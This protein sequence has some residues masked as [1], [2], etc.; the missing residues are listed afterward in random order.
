MKTIMLS[1]VAMAAAEEGSPIGK[2]IQ[3]IAD[4]Q[5]KVQA[6]GATAQTEY[7]EFAGWC[8][9]NA[10][11]LQNE[12][13]VGTATVE[14]L[15]ATLEEEAA[16]TAALNT[17]IEELAASIET[18]EADLKAA[19]AVRAKEAADFAAEEKELVDVIDVIN[20]AVGILEKEMAKSGASMLQTKDVNTVT[21]V[22]TT[23]V[24]A[25]ALSTA[26]ASKLTAFVQSRSSDDDDSA[27]A[28]AAATYEN[29]SGGIVDTLAGLGKEAEG[30]LDEA[31]KKEGVALHQFNMLKASL[32]DS[33][34]FATKESDAAKQGIAA[35][36]GT[37]EQAKGDLNVSSKDLATDTA[38][39]ADLHSNCLTRAEDHESAVK[40]RGEELAALAKA[41]EII[42][43]ATGGAASFLQVSADKTTRA[44]RLVR[45][46]AQQ[47]NSPMLAQLASRMA[48]T[49]RLN[50]GDVFGKVK[51]LINDMIDKLEEEAEADATEKAYCDKMLGEENAKREE[52]EGAIGKLSTQIDQQSAKAA[53]LKEQVA[54]LTKELGELAT[55]QAKMDQMR[56]DE[57]ATFDHAEAETA[58][59][60]EGIKLAL[61]TLRDYYAKADKSHGSSDG[62]AGGIVS[63]LEVCESDFSKELAELRSNEQ[64]AVAAYESETK[65]NKMAK[66]EKS[67]D[68]KYKEKEAVSLA[69]AAS[70]A[71]SDRTGLQAEL[72]AVLETLKNLDDR[73]S[74][75]AESYGDR[76]A[77][78][79]A[80]I[81]GLKEALEILSSEAFVQSGRKSLRGVAR[82]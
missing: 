61:K 66:T 22:L 26:D 13:K 49:A 20:R 11:N 78:R 42:I 67:Q 23:L 40:S 75:K 36:A 44:E 33:V 76:T 38:S 58:K 64:S 77:A 53:K 14:E 4:L 79:A 12:I 7:E 10:K 71:T 72:D 69:K 62:A 68:V 56:G 81:A 73:C 82:H 45:D 21:Q 65:E 2:V 8:E 19:T 34:K 32:T 63:L 60:L 52:L 59:G 39:L 51:G 3:M 48:S 47:H 5:G 24:Q 16:K 74:E 25:T 6:E 57:K 27:S 28:P 70:E 31:R 50:S 43:E 35:S 17:K 80:E 37:Q 1:V 55:S 9:E 46:L 15:K 30:Q 54:T 29:Q 18:D 41:K